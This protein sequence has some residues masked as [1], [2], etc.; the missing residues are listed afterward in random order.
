MSKDLWVILPH[1]DDEDQKKGHLTRL[2]LIDA[3]DSLSDLQKI[4][5][6]LI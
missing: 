1:E 4:V 5:G 6:G 2:V 3:E